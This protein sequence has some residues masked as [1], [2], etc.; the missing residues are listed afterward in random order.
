M[1]GRSKITHFCAILAFN[2]EPKK[3]KS[4]KD[5]E[6]STFFGEKA[7]FLGKNYEILTRIWAVFDVLPVGVGDES[8]EN[9]VAE[10]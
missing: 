6:K 1:L 7:R 9:N 5:H 2:E 8:I 4:P 3:E 10:R